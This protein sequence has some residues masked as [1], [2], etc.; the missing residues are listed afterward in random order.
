MIS[1]KTKAQAGISDFHVQDSLISPPRVSFVCPQR[2]PLSLLG[3]KEA[4]SARNSV[5][6]GRRKKEIVISS[7]TQGKEGGGPLCMKQDS[8]PLETA[9]SHLTSGASSPSLPSFLAAEKEGARKQLSLVPTEEEAP[10]G[11]P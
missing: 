2:G 6:K 11:T 4:L 10:L 9:L 7:P 1:F 8:P 5:K 3:H